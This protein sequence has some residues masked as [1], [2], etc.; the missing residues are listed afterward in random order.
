MPSF[1]V[2]GDVHGCLPELLALLGRLGYGVDA[3][4]HLTPPLGRQLVLVGDLVDRG[5]DT[6]GVLRLVM[7]AVAAGQAVAVRGN[8]D[9][10]LGHALSGGPVRK[11]TANLEGSLKQ[12]AAESPTFRRRAAAFLL[13]LPPRL[14]LDEGRLLVAHAGDRAD[15]AGSERGEYNVHGYDF[16]E[17]DAYGQIVREDW[18]ALHTGPHLIVSGHTPVRQPQRRGLRGVGECLNI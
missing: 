14:S 10:R 17:R 13:S 16:E 5:P 1:D 11:P 18:A 12:L 15:L 2:I 4:L 8:H 6:L 9:E 3:E 7:N